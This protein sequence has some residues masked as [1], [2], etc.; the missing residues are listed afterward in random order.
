MYC[1]EGQGLLEVDSP[2]I[3]V[4]TRFCHSHAV[5]LKVV[6]WPLPSCFKTSPPTGQYI[7]KYRFTDFFK[8]VNSVKSFHLRNQGSYILYLSYF[9][10]PGPVT[11]VIQES[12]SLILEQKLEAACVAL[13]HFF[14]PLVPGSSSYPSLLGREEEN[15]VVS[16]PYQTLW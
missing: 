10:R 16:L 15:K 7:S 8:A 13:G 5:L 3:L 6:P 2:A 1:S 14:C 4:L 11:F 12:D 9:P